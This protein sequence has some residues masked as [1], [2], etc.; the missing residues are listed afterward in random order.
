MGELRCC[1][2]NRYQNR[3]GCSPR[4]SWG[5]GF[6]LCRVAPASSSPASLSFPS[7]HARAD[8]DTQHTHTH[9]V[10]HTPHSSA[11]LS[12][13]QHSTALHCTARRSSRAQQAWRFLDTRGG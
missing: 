13:A 9:D 1:V 3:S 4:V 2:R 5:Y 12:T 7:P 8:T 11:H 10:M 6:L